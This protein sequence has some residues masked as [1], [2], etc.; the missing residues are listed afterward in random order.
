MSQLSMTSRYC[1]R[2]RQSRYDTMPAA[3]FVITGNI[4]VGLL[5]FCLLFNHSQ[6]V[7]SVSSSLKK[8]IF[9]FVHQFCNRYGH[10]LCIVSH[11]VF[12]GCYNLNSGSLLKAVVGPVEVEI[13]TVIWWVAVISWTLMPHLLFFYF[14]KRRLENITLFHII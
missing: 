13:L 4:P 2:H 5:H 8:I 11:F 7:Y 14:P 12:Q 1:I 10:V 9:S 6:L 3:S